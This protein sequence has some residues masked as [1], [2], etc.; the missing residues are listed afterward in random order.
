MATRT[1]DDILNELRA[2]LRLADSRYQELLTVTKL[3]KAMEASSAEERLEA[4]ATLIAS[5]F[6]D[7]EKIQAT[8]LNEILDGLA[9]K[10]VVKIIGNGISGKDLATILG[11]PSEEAA[12]QWVFRRGLRLAP[13][14]KST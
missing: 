8:G 6:R 5:L 11:L 13:P 4:I 2:A 9:L 7:G 3:Q 10:T 12:R 1:V 14:H